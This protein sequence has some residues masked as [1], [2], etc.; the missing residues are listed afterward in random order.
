VIMK[1]V[2]ASLTPADFYRGMEVMWRGRAVHL[3]EYVK[4]DDYG[5]WFVKF[6][7]T[8]GQLS[9]SSCHESEKQEVTLHNKTRLRKPEE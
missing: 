5:L 8:E 9:I 6:H 2:L 1:R 3:D 7:I 4:L